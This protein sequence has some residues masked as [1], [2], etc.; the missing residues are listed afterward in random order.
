MTYYI[1]DILVSSKDEESPILEELVDL[2]NTI[3]C[4]IRRYVSSC[5]LVLNS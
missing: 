2:S 1:D 4:S 5:L 3:S